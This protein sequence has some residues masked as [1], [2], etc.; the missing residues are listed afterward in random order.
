MGKNSCVA[1][2][3]TSDAGSAMIGSTTPRSLDTFWV[4]W[5]LGE[6]NV[7]GGSGGEGGGGRR[8]CARAENEK[9][10]NA[11]SIAAEPKNER[12]GCAVRQREIV[13]RGLFHRGE[14]PSPKS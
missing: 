14:P 2:T 3:D 10:K 11:P 7:D 1:L 6:F 9:Y 4:G 13:D 8:M 12:F 5:A